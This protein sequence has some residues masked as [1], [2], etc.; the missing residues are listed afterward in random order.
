METKV[1]EHGIELD[2][3]ANGLYGAYAPTGF[4]FRFSGLHTIGYA[5]STMKEVRQ[6]IKEDGGLSACPEGCNGTGEHAI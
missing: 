2:K 1:I 5:G 4:Y 6:S 3:D